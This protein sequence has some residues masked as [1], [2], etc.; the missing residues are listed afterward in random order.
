MGVRCFWPHNMIGRMGLVVDQALTLRFVPTSHQC[1][2]RIHLHLSRSGVACSS[3]DR[4]LFLPCQHY[5]GDPRRLV[6][7]RDNR[8]IKA[9]PGDQRF[10]PC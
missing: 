4:V 2:P 8:S 10:Q 1:S 5:P 9:A 6:G 3:S 7:E